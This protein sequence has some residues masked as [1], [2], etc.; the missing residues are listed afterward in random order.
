MARSE[1]LARNI[2]RIV[3][4]AQPPAY[5]SKTLIETEVAT[6]DGS[7]RPGLLEIKTPRDR[8]SGD[9]AEDMTAISIKTERDGSL[10]TVVVE[11]DELIRAIRDN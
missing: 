9:L 10:T 8:D 4:M 2:G 1:R 7:A 11:T 3:S 5:C 6:Q